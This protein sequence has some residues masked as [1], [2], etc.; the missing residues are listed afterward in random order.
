M[1][2]LSGVEKRVDKKS[3]FNTVLFVDDETLVLDFLEDAFS[4]DYNVL[5]ARSGE[6]ALRILGEQP[7]SVI[8]TDM[9]MAGMTGVELLSIVQEQFPETVRLLMTAFRDVEDVIEAVNRGHIYQFLH[10]PLKDVELRQILDQA[11]RYR[12]LSQENSLLADE[13]MRVNRQLEGK[14]E[15]GTQKLATKNRQLETHLRQSERLAQ[16]SHRINLL[17]YNR[18]FD[19]LHE[20]LPS[21]LDIDLFSL[22]EVKR[23][24]L[25]GVEEEQSVTICR[26]HNHPM[27]ID[28]R[29]HPLKEVNPGLMR[30]VIE[31]AR[32]IMVES[33]SRS[34]YHRG[35]VRPKYR[36]D[37]CCTVPLMI[38]GILIGVL[39]L[40]GRE[41][42]R[43]NDESMA[44]FNHVGENLASALSNC[45]LHLKTQQLAITDGLTKL[46]NI[47]HFLERME[48]EISRARRFSAPLSCIMI[49]LDHFKQIND[50]YGHD[51]GNQVL[52]RVARILLASKRKIDLLGRFGGEEFIVTLPETG[53]VGAL[54]VARRMQ[55]NIKAF[56]FLC[57]GKHAPISASFGVATMNGKAINR[58]T[59]IRYADMALYRAKDEGRDRIVY[60]PPPPGK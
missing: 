22:F 40:S 52:K 37:S 55:E 31:G 29:E 17:S 4:E 15:D 30:D 16:F 13:L 49:D 57:R 32:P 8:I 11:I 23:R 12:R 14:V 27:G 5:R 48:E 41:D 1:P 51:E 60:Q 3:G 9:R 10:K 33:F 47:G 59:L 21:L 28:D 25:E 56:K 36:G 44:L 42:Q 24:L 6:E 54:E 39:N 38:D 2:L 45:A 43:F 19:V 50:Q 53:R 7:V 35:W 34:D 46:Y 58:D 20:E 18:L 26:V